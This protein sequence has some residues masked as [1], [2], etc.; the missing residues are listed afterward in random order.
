M[1]QVVLLNLTSLRSLLKQASAI[2]E[3]GSELPHSERRCS[4]TVGVVTGGVWGSQG[5]R[6]RLNLGLGE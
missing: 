5:F 2:R 4:N 3:S 6:L 1:I